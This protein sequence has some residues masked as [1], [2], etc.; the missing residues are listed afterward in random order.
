MTRAGWRGAGEGRTFDSGRLTIRFDLI[1]ARADM[2]RGLAVDALGAKAAAVDP[3]LQSG[4]LQSEIGAAFPCRSDPLD[5]IGNQPRFF[6]VPGTVGQEQ[7]PLAGLDVPVDQDKVGMGVM[8]VLVLVMDGVEPWHAACGEQRQERAHQLG[9]LRA[10]QLAGQ[11]DA[12]FAA[13]PGVLPRL[14]LLR[15]HPA[16]RRL[17]MGRH[18][19]RLD[20]GGGAAPAD[21]AEMRS[22]RA[23]RMGRAADGRDST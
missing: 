6:A 23:R 21:I 12:D 17:R 20:R 16:A 5:A 2:D 1:G 3:V 14:A 19:R 22:G 13:E 7:D 8:P 18:V 11:G 4:A 10:G 15:I 9:I